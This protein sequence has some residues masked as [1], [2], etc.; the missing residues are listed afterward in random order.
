MHRPAPRPILDQIPPQSCLGTKP[1]VDLGRPGIQWEFA[2]YRDIPVA[3]GFLGSA[4][5]N[6]LVGTVK[7]ANVPAKG[8]AAKASPRRLPWLLRKKDDRWSAPAGYDWRAG[9]MTVRADR[10]TRPGGTAREKV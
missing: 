10:G 8:V 7:G 6:F 9:A 4:R 5:M 3:A 1:R 2:R